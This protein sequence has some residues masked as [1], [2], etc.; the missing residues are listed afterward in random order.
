MDFHLGSL[1]LEELM[2][3]MK[4]RVPTEKEDTREAPHEPLRSLDTGG[5]ILSR[6]AADCREREREREKFLRGRQRFRGLN[7]RGP[8]P[9]QTLSGLT[10][11]CP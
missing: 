5:G 7:T 11:H 3:G 1:K 2:E 10:G 9:G 4:E 6:R 8:V